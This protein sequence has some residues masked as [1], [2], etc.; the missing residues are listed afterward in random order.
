MADHKPWDRAVAWAE[1]DAFFEQCEAEGPAKTD[2]DRERLQR[3]FLE[4]MERCNARALAI[5]ERAVSGNSAP[6]LHLVPTDR[7]P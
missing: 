6:H 4:I 1:M 3:Q 2:G 7:K 5:F